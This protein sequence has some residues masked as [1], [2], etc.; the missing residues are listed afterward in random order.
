MVMQ[1]LVPSLYSKK[2]VGLS[3]LGDWG[4]FC[5][6]FVLLVHMWAFPGCFGC[7]L[8]SE[9]M[10]VRLT[11]YYNCRYISILKNSTCQSEYE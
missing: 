4:L 10:W 11:G 1:W 6:E 9:Y 3:L 8:L 5:V 2:V 7:F